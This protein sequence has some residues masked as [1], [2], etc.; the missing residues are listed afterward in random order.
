MA[1]SRTRRR[2]LLLLPLVLTGALVGSGIR[3]ATAAVD[4]PS[5]RAV[6]ITAADGVV[7]KAHLVEPATPGRH[8]AIVFINSWGI[9]D[10]EYLVQ[11]NTLADQGYV[12]LSYTTRGFWSSGG[13]IET[14]GPLDIADVSTAIDWLI[15]HTNADAGRI[16]MAGVSYGSGISLIAAAFDPRIKAVVAMSTWSDLVASLYGEQT[17]RPQAVFLLAAL[18]NLVGR[19]SAELSQVIDDYFA[20]RNLDRITAFARL[21]SASSYVDAI[22]R[23]HPA[24]LLAN[25]Y[26]DS[27]FPPN[28]LVDFF[29]RLTGPKR[30]ELAAGDHA[31]VEATGLVGLDNHVW[32]SL[33]RW[34][35]QYLAGADTGIAAE[36]P[37]VLRVRNTGA[38][39]ASADWASVTASTQRLGLGPVRWWDGTGALA[40]GPAPTGWSRTI[41]TG[42]D[43]TADA[44]VA[45]LSNGFEALSGVPPTVWLPSVDRL[46]AGVWVGDPLPAG[47]PVRGIAR[48]HLTLRPASA[49]GTVVAYLY[50]LDGTGTGAL[51]THAPTTWLS[52]V[53]GAQLT[54]DL[55]LPA[56]AY[57]VPAGHRLALVV[58]TADPLYLGANPVG[59]A[60]TFGGPSWLDVPLA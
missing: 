31:V 52:A 23:N 33:Y 60:I 51:V 43:T 2:L 37:V 11:A 46:H 40:A 34:F 30:L 45:L 4:T 25:A 38:V 54:L 3:S 55:A 50:D 26:G 24:I 20:N 12:V 47:A 17:R 56:M 57:D 5:A 59:A 13:R 42:L 48:L 27:L 35:G 15:G 53:A 36:P 58:D 44:G 39:D 21:R 41:W 10:R 1:R 22:N 32:T 7:L 28:Q 14:A 6:D 29:G 19:P 16:G 9:D 8:P 18:A 49:S